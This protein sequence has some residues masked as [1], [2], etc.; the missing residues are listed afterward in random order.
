MSKY[1]GIYNNIDFKDKRTVKNL[2]YYR[3]YFESTSFTSDG[4]LF[5][6]VGINHDTYSDLIGIYADLDVII[7]ECEFTEK[8]LK[9]L[10]LVEGGYTINHIYTIFEEYEM[11]S[12]HKMFNRIVER[13]NKKQKEKEDE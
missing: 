6:R 1:N 8:N 4:S 13:I 2:L 9:L 11:E 5:N 12:T 3:H 7:N 10:N